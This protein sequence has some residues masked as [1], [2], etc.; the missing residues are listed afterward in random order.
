MTAVRLRLGVGDYDLTRAIITD[1]AEAPGFALEVHT[2]MQAGD[3]HRGMLDG[4]FDASE[5]SLANYLIARSEG[6]RL[7]AIPA[8]PNRAFRH[9]SIYVNRAAGIQEPRDLEGRRVGM[10]GWVSTASMWLRGMLQHY[11]GVD[12]RR[13]RWVA[14]PDYFAWHL[15]TGI[16]VAPL[17]PGQSLDAMLVRGELDALM[18]PDA[19]PSIQRGAPEVERLFAHYRAADQEYFRRTGVFPISHLVV[20]SESYLE[21]HP[22]APASLLGA[23]RAARDAAFRRLEDQEVLALSWAGAALAEQRALMGPRYWPYDVASNRAV[24]D[25]A[26]ACAHEQGLIPRPLAVDELFVP[27]TLHD[28]DR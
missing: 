23:F 4:A 14:R 1:E 10:R 12:L 21:A 17:Q 26:V 13:V 15:P 22:T 9:A 19:P 11:Y 16:T 25:L 2:G 24:L 6:R 5:F 18:T 3:R 8:F 20:L 27:T 7:W 28:A